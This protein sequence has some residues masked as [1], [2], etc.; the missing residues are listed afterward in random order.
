MFVESI[1]LGLKIAIRMHV[2][3]KTAIVIIEA[4]Y[5]EVVDSKL[6][7]ANESLVGWLIYSCTSKPDNSQ[8]GRS[9][10]L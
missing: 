2:T 9:D 8:L 1:L 3:L 4:L 6:D 7:I 10:R 5:S